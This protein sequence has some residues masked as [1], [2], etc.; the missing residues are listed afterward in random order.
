[1]GEPCLRA[2]LGEQGTQVYLVL[3]V[4]HLLVLL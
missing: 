3:V 4:N 2:S 1:M